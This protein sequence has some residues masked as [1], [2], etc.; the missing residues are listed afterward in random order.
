[1]KTIIL[2]I[3]LLFSFSSF[4]QIEG[5][6]NGNIEIP[7]NELPF[8]VHITKEGNELKAT[9]GSPDQGAFDIEMPEIRF[10]NNTLHLAHPQMMMTYEGTLINE[11]AINGT[12]KQGGQSFTLN[13]TKGEFKRNRPQEPQPP[14][15]YKTEDITFENKEA[16]IKL[17]GTLTIPNGNKKFPVVVLVAG[18]GPNDRNEELFG[19]K[20]FLV[21]A[22]HLTKN[23]YAVLRYDK[24]GVASSEGDFA[25]ATVFDFANDT[26]AAIDYLKIRKEIDN[27]K[28]GILGHSEGGMVAQIIV[29]EDTSLD[30]IILMAAP[31]IKGSEVLILQTDILAKTMEVPESTRA[32][33]KKVNNDIYNIIMESNDIDL[34]KKELFAYYESHSS[35]SQL[36]KEQI[37]QQVLNSTTDWTRAFLKF[38][39]Q[40]YLPKINCHVLAINGTKDLQV[41]SVENL[42]GISKGLG[43]KGN[44]KIISYEGLNHL[45]QAATTGLPDEYGMIETT[46]EPKVLEDIVQWLNEKVK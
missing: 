45:F 5:T 21:L 2:F 13:L 6:W 28:I 15:S 9:F 23:G 10:G 11:N 37:N 46:I 22:D 39:P 33:N 17:A 27:D 42:A 4:A 41:T 44:L 43:M 36:S 12:F 32:I 18:S 14:F 7:S 24:R 20:P 34:A 38:N 3:S 25:S 29:S 40:D 30:F 35:L 8:G 26:K 16:G 19:H 1:M 31:G